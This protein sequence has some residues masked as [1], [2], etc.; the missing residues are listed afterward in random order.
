M[1]LKMLPK[2]LDNK[3]MYFN[4]YLFDSFPKYFC[5]FE[6]RDEVGMMRGKYVFNPVVLFCSL[7]FCNS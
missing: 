7:F 6:G 5:L 4:L 2:N 3:R 1:Y